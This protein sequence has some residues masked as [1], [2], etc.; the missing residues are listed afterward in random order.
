MPNLDNPRG[1]D[2]AIIIEDNAFK[3]VVP[4][5]L[6]ASPGQ[7]V[8]WVITPGGQDAELSFADENDSPLDWSTKKNVGNKIQ[9]TVKRDAKGLY[10]YSVTANGVTIDPHIRIK[11]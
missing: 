3:M 4:D 2:A 1:I 5:D 6:E 11:P 10:K 7:L 8:T 9:G